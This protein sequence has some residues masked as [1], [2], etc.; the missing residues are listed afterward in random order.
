MM[1]KLD[2]RAAIGLLLVLAT[3][4]AGALLHVYQ[5]GIGQ[6]S[7]P[8]LSAKSGDSVPA[9]GLDDPLSAAFQHAVMLQHS[10]RTEA[11]VDAWDRVL[12]LAPDLPEAHV[13]KGFALIDQDNCDLAQVSFDRAL[14]LRP[15]QENAYYGQALCHE[16]KGDLDL[17]RGAMRVY[18]HLADNESPYAR[19]AMAAIWEWSAG[20]GAAKTSENNMASRAESIDDG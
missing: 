18:V 1:K 4:A 17:A 6:F 14:A 12:N 15:Q 2:R 11:A 9:S 5:S 7:S 20:R 8:L 13:N 10:G 19:R 16:R 3:L